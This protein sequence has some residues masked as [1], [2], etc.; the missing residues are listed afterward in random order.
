MP[1]GL[2]GRLPH[3][4]A[5]VARAPQLGRHLMATARPPPVLDR[6]AVAYEPKMYAND[7]LPCCSATGLANHVRAVGA[8]GQATP[9]I[10]YA[11]I[12]AFYAASIGVPNDANLAATPGAV[13]LDVLNYQRRHGF[14]VGE[15][16]ALV[17]D[18]AAGDPGNRDQLANTM[19]QLG[20]GY[21][22]VELSVSDQNMS[23]WDTENVPTSAGDPTPGSWGGHCLVAWDY[24]GLIDTDIVRLATWGGWQL[25]TWRWVQARLVEAYAL[26][27]PQLRSPTGFA[28]NGMD[29]AKLT[30]DNYA[31]I[32]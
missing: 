31:W 5:A 21:W 6:H 19:Y 10:T 24:D 27:W 12:P 7:Y 16:V 2:L 28:W 13:L 29:L 30:D 25:A 14:D 17:A 4:P 32:E 3:D 9:P 15:Q 23:V 8:L 11:T 20:A 1:R 18:V 22:G 26:R